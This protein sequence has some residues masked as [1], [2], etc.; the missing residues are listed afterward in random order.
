MNFDLESGVAVLARTP[1]A[2]TALLSGLPDG[3]TRRNEGEG[4]WSPYDV[5]GHLIHGERTDW[6]P[7]VRMILEAAQERIAARQPAVRV[8]APAAAAAPAQ[9]ALVTS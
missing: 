5:V 1:G 3:W 4:T 9:P 8:A 7:R 6:M 2:L